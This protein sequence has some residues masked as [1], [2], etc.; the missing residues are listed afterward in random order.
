MRSTRFIIWSGR[1]H[2]DQIIFQ[3]EAQPT[4][5][6]GS[7]SPRIKAATSL[8]LRFLTFA[9]PLQS[10]N[11]T[12]KE[13]NW[14][15]QSN[16]PQTINRS[17]AVVNRTG[18]NTPTHRQLQRRNVSSL[19]RFHPLRSAR[20][21]SWSVWHCSIDSPRGQHETLAPVHGR[22]MLNKRLLFPEMCFP[23]RRAV[24]TKFCC[25]LVDGKVLLDRFRRSRFFLHL[26]NV[27]W[28]ARTLMNR[29][30]SRPAFSVTTLV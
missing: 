13:T 6:N 4:A 3:L 29:F 23:D 21:L 17:F 24:H 26:V 28:S 25:D 15:A 5:A 20:D 2:C 14:L 30:H 11:L 7:H 27:S 8:M 22:L 1:T 19:K 9:I 18:R 10:F 12:A 16:D